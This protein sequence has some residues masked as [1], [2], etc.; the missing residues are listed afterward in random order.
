MQAKKIPVEER[1][2]FAL[3]VP[4]PD[5]ARE[6]V[7]MLEP[8][9]NFFKVG[10]Q[11]FLAGG[12]R[13]VDWIIGRG[14]RVML[15]LKF[16]DIPKTVELAVRQLD[17]HGI[18][19][20]TVHGNRAIMEAAASAVN[21]LGILAVT[22]LTSMGEEELKELGAVVSI[23]ELVLKRA[24]SAG[25]AG[26]AGVVCSPREVRAVREKT[27]D[28]LIVVTPGIRPS[29]KGY[30]MP[31]DQ[32]RTATP[33][34]AILNGSDYLVIGRPIREADDPLAAVSAMRHEIGLALEEMAQ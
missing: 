19:F 22:V 30:A 24:V 34:S 21:G 13:I 15:D 28:S 27:G 23:E 12:F 25:R 6:L 18:T 10:L 7:T 8:E 2:I 9:V 11:L 26:C 33:Y 5:E 20:A 14:H 29:S 16:Y 17:G 1:I 3:D 32:V 4:G 31:D